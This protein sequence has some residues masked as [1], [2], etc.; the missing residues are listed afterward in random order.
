MP[1]SRHQWADKITTAANA[2]K[3]GIARCHSDASLQGI[4]VWQCGPA[5][6]TALCVVGHV[7]A[8]RRCQNSSGAERETMRLCPRTWFL[9]QSKLRSN[10]VHPDVYP[11]SLARTSEGN[12]WLSAARCSATRIDNVMHI[13]EL[14]CV[15]TSVFDCYRQFR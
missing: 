5:C 6:A 13:V 10:D 7:H 2:Q 3:L 8:V 4:C 15:C 12:T 14:V 11:S 1:T 9:L